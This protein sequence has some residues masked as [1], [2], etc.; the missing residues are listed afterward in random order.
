MFFKKKLLSETE[1]S[2]KFAKQLTKK[3]KSLKII[4]INELEVKSEFNEGKHQHFL[5]VKI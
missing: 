2:E 5:K 1:F 4:S 3:V